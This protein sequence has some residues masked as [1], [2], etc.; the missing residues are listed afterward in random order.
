[1]DWANIEKWDYIVQ[2]VASEYS[3]KYEMVELDDIRQ[4]LYKWFVEHPN[5]L[6]EWEAI[7]EKDAKNLIY[8]SLRNDALDYCQRWKAKSSGYETSD[9]FY[10]DAAM[11]E[12][13]LPSVIRGEIG[14][15]HKLN[16]AGPSKPPAPAEGGNMM[17]MM[18]EIDK[19]YNKLSTED[20]TV[21]FYKYAESFDYST[22]ATEMNLGSEDAAR[23]RH[24]R[25]I[26]KLI[27]RVGGFRPW[28]D[29]DI[30]EKPA[31]EPDE[32]VEQNEESD[33]N[34]REEYSEDG[35]E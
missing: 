20:R 11:I 19:A 23:M 4:S 25:A 3:R 30:D 29:Q 5:K 31:Q 10:Y 27:V 17:V 35:A 28:L 16:L 8:R 7:G 24:N 9:V 22:I 6:K 2:A 34:E 18:I 15:A 33:D 26:K 21:L 1:M 12:A 14:V 32:L 13:L